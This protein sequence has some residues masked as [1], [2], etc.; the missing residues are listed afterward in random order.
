MS[1]KICFKCNIEKGL[2][3]YYKHNG[4]SDGHLNKCKDC[5]KKYSFDREKLLR[6]NQDWVEKEKARA[7]EKYHRLNYKD[8]YKPSKEK[9]KEIMGR[10]YEKYPEKMAAKSAMGKMKASIEGYEL[11]HWSYNLQHA[12][13]VIELSVINHNK[14]HRYLI[15]DQERMMYRRIDTNELLDTREVHENYIFNVI[16]K[17]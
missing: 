5:C 9:R 1:K 6:D 3:E 12:K 10:Y 11:H 4:M 8:I 17:N 15:Y 2:S 13:D 16:E 7:R 14:A